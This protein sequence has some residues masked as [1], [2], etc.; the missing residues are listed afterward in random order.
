MAVIRLS[1]PYGTR[2]IGSHFEPQDDVLG[3][4]Q[5]VP[6]ARREAAKTVT[7]PNTRV[8]HDER[9]IPAIA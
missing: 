6:T 2:V 4:A 3:Y 8:P 7:H 5:T 1:R 9:D